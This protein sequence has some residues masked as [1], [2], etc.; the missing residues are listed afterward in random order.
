LVP[1]VSYER[2]KIWI[3]SKS[4]E[5]GKKVKKKRRKGEREKVGVREGRR[6]II[7]KKK[8]TRGKTRAN[9]RNIIPM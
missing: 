9:G 5:E 4:I 7:E 8:G 6:E 1:L 2:S 3:F